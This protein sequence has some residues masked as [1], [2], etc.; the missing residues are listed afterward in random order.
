MT[1]CSVDHGFPTSVVDG[2]VGNLFT[3][4]FLGQSKGR[5]YSVAVNSQCSETSSAGTTAWHASL[6]ELSGSILSILGICV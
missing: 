3:P 2:Q 6:S 1:V 5:E 4:A